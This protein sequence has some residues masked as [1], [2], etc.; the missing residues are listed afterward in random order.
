MIWNFARPDPRVIKLSK[1]KKQGVPYVG[2][3][4]DHSGAQIMDC[5]VDHLVARIPIP[6]LLHACYES[7]K[8][9]LRWYTLLF[10]PGYGYGGTYFDTKH[11]YIY[12]GHQERKLLVNPTWPS[13]YHNEE[14]ADRCLWIKDRQSVPNIA[15]QRKGRS[16]YVAVL[17]I[18]PL[19][20]SG[21]CNEL[22]KDVLFLGSVSPSLREGTMLRI[23]G[24]LPGYSKGRI[25]RP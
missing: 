6:N 23:S 14:E 13:G 12:Y 8:L 22:A 1:S 10:R 21:W 17:A 2:T 19:I 16:R 15:V 24:N 7:R 3:S 9:V 5:S 11:D 20:I 25:F 4:L 18:D